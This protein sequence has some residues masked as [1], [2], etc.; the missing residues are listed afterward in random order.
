MVTENKQQQ[1]MNEMNLLNVR[2]NDLFN[3]LNRTVGLLFEEN[4]KLVAE[5]EQLKSEG[6]VKIEK[7]NKLL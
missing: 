2:I 5:L 4:Q 6:G 7:P 3:Q 1:I